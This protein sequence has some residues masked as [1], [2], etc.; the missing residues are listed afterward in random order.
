[1]MVI[2]FLNLI[3]FLLLSMMVQLVFFNSTTIW[4]YLFYKIWEGDMI[5]HDYVYCRSYILFKEF[6]KNKYVC[7]NISYMLVQL[8]FTILSS[9][10]LDQLLQKTMNN[11]WRN[12]ALILGQ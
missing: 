12:G 5:S 1:M 3:I 10:V 6:S 11:K 9:I 2:A 7:I 8:N 4:L